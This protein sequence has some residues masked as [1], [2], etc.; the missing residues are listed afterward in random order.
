MK[1]LLATN[2]RIVFND[3]KYYAKSKFS[4]IIF[5]YYESFGKMILCSRMDTYRD[6]DN[7]L[8][9]ISTCIEKYIKIDSLLK[10]YLLKYN[11]V[12]KQNLKN[13]DLVVARCPS[14]IG[15]R[16]ISLTKT[17]YFVE[18]MGCPWDAYWNHGPVGKIMAPFM[19]LKMRMV[20]KKA[21]YALYVTEKFL[22]HRYPCRAYSISA[23]NV[24]ISPAPDMVIANRVKNV[25][26]INTNSSISL[27]TSA[28]IDVPYK[29]QKYVIQA[30]KILKERGIIVQYYLAGGGDK[31][32]LYN[33]AKKC[34]VIDN[35]H[36]LG[37]IT[38]S[39]ILKQ[40]DN[41]DIYIQPSLQEG[42]PRAVI[43]AMSR[44]CAVIGSKTAGIP[45]L[46]QVAMLVRRKSSLDIA[47]KI[48]QYI[49][50]SGLEKE[51]ISL[52]NY[53][54]SKK[55]DRDLLDDK[56]KKYFDYIIKDMQNR[57]KQ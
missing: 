20:L 55:Y 44:G 47:N 56:R 37:E 50:L 8:V 28:A 12:I 43:E 52:E 30:I 16:V 13:V 18:V 9:D 45:E 32:K 29:G 5:R 31:T 27:M 17:K 41:T 42:L 11:K 21:D 2:Y 15:F 54:N 40:L 33:I 38:S 24:N 19:Y 1:V 7:T 39:D 23:S 49:K 6:D 26:N 35:V 57:N 53:D 25:Y 36:F 48:E 51:K 10:L 34:G 46:I 4:S 14:G 3:G 22:Q